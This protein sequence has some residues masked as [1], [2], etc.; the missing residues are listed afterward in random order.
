MVACCALA[1]RLFCQHADKEGQQQRNP[2][3]CFN[4]PRQPQNTRSPSCSPRSARSSSARC[5]PP[6]CRATQP[7]S[8]APRASRRCAAASAARRRASRRC[9]RARR[10][11]A[12]RARR[13]QR[14]RPACSRSARRTSSC[15]VSLSS[16]AACCCCACCLRRGGAA[17]KV[18]QWTEFLTSPPPH[19]HPERGINNK[20]NSPAPAAARAA[21]GAAADGRVRARR[22]VRRGA[23]FGRLH[24]A[25]RRARA[26]CWR[27]GRGASAGGGGG[28][29]G[30][31]GVCK[32]EGASLASPWSWAPC[33]ALSPTAHL[34]SNHHARTPL[35]ARPPARSPSSLGL[36]HPDLAVVR[37][38][39]RQ[40][41]EASAAML[42][43]L[44]QRLRGPVQLPEC[45]RAVGYLRRMGAFTE[46]EL[47][48]QFLRCREAWCAFVFLCLFLSVPACRARVVLF[49][50]ATPSTPKANNMLQHHTATHKTQ[51]NT[52]QRNTT[53]HQHIKKGSPRSSPSSTPATPTSLCGR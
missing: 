18:L 21:R 2:T 51:R 13:S 42:A 33:G 35:P 37:L 1:L 53:T 28:G 38:L 50:S 32:G 8:A 52:T 3:Q 29:G 22:R 24:R 43:Q 48:L 14:T 44:L 45:L 41:A 5:S 31:G 15:S 39:Q 10:R 47:R 25:V 19:F 34:I 20:T 11:S 7:S 4:N 40:A 46:A 49:L 27:R 26:V 36:L 9:R 12:R 6:R 30:G 17:S 23:R 16:L